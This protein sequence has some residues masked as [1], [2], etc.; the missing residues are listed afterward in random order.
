VTSTEQFISSLV[1]ALAW[2]TAGVVLAVVFRGPRVILLEALRR[3]RAGPVE[4][5]FDRVF[6]K[7]EAEVSSDAQAAA[8]GAVLSVELAE[9]ARQSPATAILEAY[10]RVDTRLREL[11]EAQ[12]EKPVTAAG[13]VGL[14]LLAEQAHLV[15][16][17][18]VKAVE[19]LSVLRNLAAHSRTDVTVDRAMEY[20][21]LA[22]AV[23][24]S[25]GRP[26]DEA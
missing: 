6:A 11:L 22:D 16:A 4:A 15:S 8:S 1:H 12:G 21:A 23:L 24:Y 17:E 18:N 9:L 3:L 19:G 26:S 13:A 20:L 5:E 2:P 7:V 25:V 10:A 14:A